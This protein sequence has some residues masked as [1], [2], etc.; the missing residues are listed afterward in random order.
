MKPDIKEI[1]SIKYPII[2]A[3]M[4]GGITTT[5]LVASVS[6]AGGLGMIGAG[7][8][9]ASQL[10]AQIKEVKL[11][12][13]NPFG[14]NLFIPNQFEN[15]AQKNAEAENLLKQIEDELNITD[16]YVDLPAFKE[17]RERF[18][19]QLQILIEEKVPICSF[20]FGLPEKGISDNLK[21][22]GILLIGTATTVKEAQLNEKS[23]MDAVVVQG[24]EAGG[25][26]GSFT[27]EGEEKLIGLMSLIPQAAD[28]VT[29]PVIAAGG[30]MDRRGY[31]ASFSLGAQAVQMGTAFL[32]CKESGAHLLHKKAIL[33][34]S[35]QDTVLT[36]SFSGKQARGIHNRFIS[37]LQKHEDN[38][39]DYPIQNSLTKKIRAASAAQGT[40]EYMSLWSG[41]SPMLAKD[42]TVKE[43]IN[44]LIR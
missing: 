34:A 36:A 42:Q 41:Q 24:M 15:S 28:H 37:L 4:A 25:H 6:N 35:D 9:S 40:S 26:R 38:L 27:L 17:E 8:M 21:K 31:L 11:Q 39:P 32:S 33:N 20:T 5:E 7:Y 13:S 18:Y 29:I 2:Q 43:L 14:V 44:N 23:G 19:N 22:H 1:L 16:K 3:P 30:I 10:Q 12:T